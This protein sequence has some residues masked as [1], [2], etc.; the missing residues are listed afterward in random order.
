MRGRFE[1]E[2]SRGYS[3]GQSF[4]LSLVQ[5]SEERAPSRTR[6]AAAKVLAGVVPNLFP[7]IQLENLCGKISN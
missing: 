2:L 6:S 7:H 1:G 4:Q 3:H 5:S